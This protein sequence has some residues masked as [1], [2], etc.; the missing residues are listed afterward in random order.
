MT[1]T[2]V[3][4]EVNYDPVDLYTLGHI[5]VGAVLNVVGVPFWGAAAV[6]V[7]W[8]LLER[9]A[10]VR[11][12]LQIAHPK[13]Y[14]HQDTAANALWDAAATMGGWWLGDMVRKAARE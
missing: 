12:L 11:K 14:Y 4:G 1:R 5:A 10:Q 8:E 13:A 7:G 6:G 3:P 2:A 9:P